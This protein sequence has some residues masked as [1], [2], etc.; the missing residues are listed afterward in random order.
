M[1]SSRKDADATCPTKRNARRQDAGRVKRDWT[2]DGRNRREM[3]I[4]YLTMP[5][6]IFYQEEGE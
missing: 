2:L 6:Q 4:A 5:F 3:K 1:K